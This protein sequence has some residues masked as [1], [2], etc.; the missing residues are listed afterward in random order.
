ML[1]KEVIAGFAK[2]LLSKRFDE[3]TESPDFHYELWEAACA[4]DQY[5]AIAAPRNHAKSTAGT[6]A[7]GLA[8]LL[9]REAIF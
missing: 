2:T 9:F 5:V 3:A 7:Y 1:T 6:L 8:C 4:K